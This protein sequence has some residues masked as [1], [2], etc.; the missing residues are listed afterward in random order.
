MTTLCPTIVHETMFLLPREPRIWQ[1][2]LRNRLVN[3]RDT[4]KFDGSACNQENQDFT[5]RFW[6]LFDGILG[7]LRKI[8]NFVY[9]MQFANFLYLRPLYFVCIFAEIT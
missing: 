2:R 9:F 5:P 6:V 3:K 8:V 4:S 7:I 1:D